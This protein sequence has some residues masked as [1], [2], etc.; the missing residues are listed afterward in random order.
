MDEFIKL[1]RE[2]RKTPSD[3]RALRQ[4]F[5]A[6]VSLPKA[7]K[8][9]FVGPDGAVRWA[10][11]QWKLPSLFR[12]GELV[13]IHD[14]DGGLRFA[15][16]DAVNRQEIPLLEAM[17]LHVEVLS[18]DTEATPNAV[19]GGD[20][21]SMQAVTAED[22]GVAI[23][24]MG[25]TG[26]RGRYL[27][28]GVRVVID[29]ES[30]T[31][32]SI[33]KTRW[34]ALAYGKAV[35][36]VD[37]LQAGFFTIM[38]ALAMVPYQK[39]KSFQAKFRSAVMA[40]SGLCHTKPTTGAG[41]SVYEAVDA[42]KSNV[43]EFQIG[44]RG[45]AVAPVQDIMS[46]Y[47]R[48]DHAQE[49]FLVHP[50]GKALY[51][52]SALAEVAREEDGLVAY[53]ASTDPAKYLKRLLLGKGRQVDL[54]E[55]LVDGKVSYKGNL[56][57]GVS[58]AMTLAPSL[59]P[60]F[61]GGPGAIL[62]LKDR[63]YF[64]N[65]FP[66]KVEFSISGT[67]YGIKTEHDLAQVA[68]TLPK[69]EEAL[70]PV[71]QPHGC[72]VPIQVPSELIGA[73]V[74]RVSSPERDDFGN[75]FW[76]LRVEVTER[77]GQ[78]KLR[79]SIKG[80]V[81]YTEILP[82]A[83]TLERLGLAIHGNPRG[84]LLVTSD[85][86]K[87]FGKGYS[88]SKVILA[89]ET[90]IAAYGE[91]KAYEIFRK[92]LPEEAFDETGRVRF[93]EKVDNLGGYTQ[94]M[95][96]LMDNFR[97]VITVERRV[98]KFLYQKLRVEYVGEYGG[99][100]EQRE[101]KL[102]TNVLGF[103]DTLT[104]TARGGVFVVSQTTAALEVTDLVKVESAPVSQSVSVKPSMLE[105]AS[106][107]KA[108]GLNHT[109]SMLLAGGE[110]QVNSV[111]RT[112]K[113]L[114]FNADAADP[115]RTIR[116]DDFSPENAAKLG[117]L[118]ETPIPE[119][120]PEVKFA[121]KTPWA[122][123][124]LD[125]D[126]LLALADTD[127]NHV[128]GTTQAI[129]SFLSSGNV[130]QAMSLANSLYGSISTIAHSEEFYKRLNRGSMAV[131]AKRMAVIVPEDAHRKVFL[132][133]DG[134]VARHLAEMFGCSVNELNGRLTLGYRAPMFMGVPLVITLATWVP[135]HVIGVSDEVASFD[136]GDFDGDGYFLIPVTCR[137]AGRELHGFSASAW[138]EKIYLASIG[139][140]KQLAEH[141]VETNR[142]ATKPW[143]TSARRLV[144]GEGGLVEQCSNA[145]EHQII[146]M[147]SDA[148]RADLA[149]ALASFALPDAHAYVRPELAAGLKFYV[150][151]TQLAGYSEA[152]HKAHCIAQSESP[153]RDLEFCNYA[154]KELGLTPDLARVWWECR[155]GHG[156][157]L[158][159]KAFVPSKDGFC[160][161][162]HEVL[163]ITD[164]ATRRRFGANLIAGA[165]KKLAQGEQKPSDG[166]KL[167]PSIARILVNTWIKEEGK[168]TRVVVNG[169]PEVIDIWER[170]LWLASRG[171]PAAVRLK[172]SLEEIQPLVL[173]VKTPASEE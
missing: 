116:S 125:R 36:I 132:N 113:N 78:L 115:E 72:P 59:L 39:G 3:A 84:D 66:L 150:Y 82:G 51:A 97:K 143:A 27:F 77:E 58:L 52:L 136:E 22:L 104:F 65:R 42:A 70:S 169:K 91:P 103:E 166:Q 29:H 90:L 128:L 16:L 25:G 173:G 5:A 149:L 111:K 170:I 154:V 37:P 32:N 152:W 153:T 35:K 87:A 129:A 134:V 21:L 162:D 13:R 164:A 102:G 23:I 98:P 172:V 9:H 106:F 160:S 114:V 40:C 53:V 137:R 127:A 119:W 123:Y 163:P 24:L 11:M 7:L 140:T 165:M 94:L 95:Q 64:G 41:D 83:D 158:R 43:V 124:A 138:K 80:L 76:S 44:L 122:S 131:T 74:I 14:Q 144:L 62:A 135:P 67:C 93:S 145:M 63:V 18:T 141:W 121:I 68:D 71:L 47:K 33:Q 112:L 34:S 100:E 73:K 109:A 49:P 130:S 61:A 92:I 146:H 99:H 151:E 4:E 69:V 133:P 155:N 159:K 31:F 88:G 148:N 48:M 20:N 161:V 56:D 126:T 12:F 118:A 89:V 107:A 156:E 60:L 38:A 157:Y 30:V 26:S 17:G 110:R 28:N 81:T 57:R 101:V 167:L 15:Y 55:G 85:A 117:I 96:H 139:N 8:D 142:W 46:L 2:I 1:A 54:V 168:R 120:N 10:V 45:P 79:G 19:L 75:C 86:S 171:V 105:I 147:P 6:G 108:I 50:Q